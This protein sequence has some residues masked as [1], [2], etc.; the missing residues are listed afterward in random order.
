MFK[1]GQRDCL[2]FSHLECAHSVN[3]PLELK[4]K[5][6]SYTQLNYVIEFYFNT[7]FHSYV[8]FLNLN[9]QERIKL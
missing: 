8:M 6:I 9:C 3:L 4:G 7:F 2:R 5:T 1:S